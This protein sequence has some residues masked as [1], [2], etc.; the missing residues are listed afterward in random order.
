MTL[1]IFNNSSKIGYFEASDT[2]LV[3]S[4]KAI[5]PRLIRSSDLDSHIQNGIAMQRKVGNYKIVAGIGAIPSRTEWVFDGSNYTY[6]RT[7]SI[8][9]TFNN[10]SREN[11]YRIIEKYKNAFSNKKIG[12]E[13]S[14]GLDTSLIISVLNH[15]SIDF[16]LIAF[17]SDK[18]EFRTERKIQAIYAEKTRTK[19]IPYSECVPF[20]ALQDVPLHPYPDAT[21]LFHHRQYLAAS[22]AKELGVDVLLNGDAGDNLLGHPIPLGINNMRPDGFE[23]WMISDDWTNLHVYNPLGLTYLS[24]FA[25][26]PIKRLILKLR[27]G[28]PEDSKKI[29]ARNFFK[30]ILPQEL[31]QYAYKASHDGWFANG[32]QTVVNDVYHISDL[33]YSIIKNKLIHPDLMS[34]SAMTYRFLSHAQQS[35]FLSK[36]SFAT[37]VNSYSRNGLLKN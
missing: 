17:I 13:L 36:L 15:L 8:K 33:T 9:R 1:S 12:V 11:L 35:D 31:S 21:S 14:G 32:L 6:K 10:A 18:Y 23:R 24:A 27:E 25:L 19:Y 20:W 3:S 26:S 16:S 5:K 37:W 2:S 29:W 34:Q 4:E 30:N 28:E 7:A 22:A